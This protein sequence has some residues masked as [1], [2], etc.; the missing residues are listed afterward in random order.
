MRHAIGG[1]IVFCAFVCAVILGIASGTT[2][3]PKPSPDWVMYIRTDVKTLYLC[4]ESGQ[5]IDNAPLTFG[6]EITVT[7][8][9]KKP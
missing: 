5:R 1:I 8:R 6:D 7:I 9:R 3:A 2:S 4:D